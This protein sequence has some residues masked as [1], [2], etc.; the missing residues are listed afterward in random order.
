MDLKVYIDGANDR[1]IRGSLRWM[2]PK[3]VVQLPIRPIIKL[4][5]HFFKVTISVFQNS[6]DTVKRLLKD[7]KKFIFREVLEQV[8][9]SV[10]PCAFRS[11]NST[12]AMFFSILETE[13]RRRGGQVKRRW[14]MM[15]IHF[16]SSLIDHSGSFGLQKTAAK[17]PLTKNLFPLRT[18]FSSLYYPVISEW[19]QKVT[20]H[21]G[22]IQYL[23]IS[24]VRLELIALSITLNTRFVSGRANVFINILATFI[25]M[26]L[27]FL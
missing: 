20:Q 13:R 2:W 4:S 5:R 21:N 14:W 24:S 16:S 15:L 26:A 23:D 9:H 3:I 19:V 27:V 12:R 7:M 1:Y 8:F 18:A 25:V 17:L 22:I 6:F 10:N 11:Q